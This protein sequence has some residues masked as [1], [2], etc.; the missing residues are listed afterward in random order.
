L[1]RRIGRLR[2][3]VDKAASTEALQEL[4]HRLRE[5]VVDAIAG[6]AELRAARER[7]E[8]AL[9]MQR[10]QRAEAERRG[11]LARDIQDSET[12]EI[13]AR[14]AAKHAE[15]VV[16]LEQQALS[17]ERALVGA[18][19]ELDELRSELVRAERDGPASAAERSA[20]RAWRALRAG[21]DVPEGDMPGAVPEAERK[22][23]KEAAVEQQLRELKQRLR[24]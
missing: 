19:R 15:Q 9:A 7:T 12:A 22:L 18:M 24:P 1:I 5:A 23:A 16:R 4:A 6:V 3:A 14:F 10:R 11:R 2:A 13:A 20:E 8:A 17:T 21:R